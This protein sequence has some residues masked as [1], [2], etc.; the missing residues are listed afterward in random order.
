MTYAWNRLSRRTAKARQRRT[1]T[2]Y[3]RTSR[4]QHFRIEALEP[5][6]L[7]SADPLLTPVQEELTDSALTETSVIEST[8]ATQEADTSSALPSQTPISSNVIGEPPSLLPFAQTGDLFVSETVSGSILQITPSGDVSVAIS[9]TQILD[10]V[11]T[12]IGQRPDSI[13]Y[14]Q[15]GIAFDGTSESIYFVSL[16]VVFSDLS[17]ATG[18]LRIE[19]GQVD[20]L[21]TE[22]DII[23]VT[24][25]TTAQPDGLAFDSDGV[26][27][28]NED[29]SDSVI[30]IDPNSGGITI[31]A[32]EATLMAA[33][34]NPVDIDASIVGGL[35]GAMFV[36]NE[37]SPNSILKILADGTVQLLTNDARLDDLD[38][39]LTRAPDG[40]L[41]I[42]DDGN[43]DIPN[44]PDDEIF[45]VDP[46]T[47]DV[48]VFLSTAQIQAAAG[49]A[50]IDLGAGAFDSAGNFYLTDQ[51]INSILKF[52]AS[53]L[54]SVFVSEADILAVTGEAAANLNG[55]IAFAPI[56]Q[57]PATLDLTG[58]GE[59]TQEDADIILR[60][61]FGIR[62]DAL[63][64]PSSEGSSAALTDP[65]EIATFLESLET[66]ML[67]VDDNG[68]AMALTDGLLIDRFIKGLTRNDLINGVVDPTGQRTDAGEIITFLSQFVPT[69]DPPNI[70]ASLLNDTGVNLADGL[71][72]DPTITGTITDPDG[73]NIISFR[74]GF[75]GTAEEDFVDILSTFDVNTGTFIL[76]ATDLDTINGGPLSDGLHT[77]TLIA[78]DSRGESS[79]PSPIQFT[80]DTLTPSIVLTSPLQADEL[81]VDSRLTGTASGTGTPLVQ[82]TYAF[83]SGTAIPM[84]IDQMSGVVNTP[85]DLSTLGTGDHTLTV[86][87]LDAAG[88]STTTQID[89][90]LTEL[91][92]LTIRQI[93]PALGS[94][95][96]GTTFRPQIFFSRPVDPTTLNNSNFFATDSAGQLLNATI[97]PSQDNDFAWLFFTDPMPGAETIT[98]HVEG[99][100]IL[101]LAD[102]QPLDA[103]DDGTPGGTLTSIFTTVSLTP[104]PGTTIIGQVVDPG[105]DLTP[106][107]SDDIDPGP[108]GLLHT[109]DDVFLLPLPGVKVFIL[110]M[111][112]DFVLTDSEG[113]FTL[114]NV[115]AGNVKVA[116]DGRTGPN[117]PSGVFFPEMV[118]DVMIEPGLSNTLMG[119]MGTPEQQRANE[120]REE[121]YLPRIQQT[122]LQ[123]VSNTEETMVGVDEMSAPNLT[124]EQ[125]EQ[126]QLMVQPGSLIDENGN[127]IAS[128]QVGLSTVPPELVREMLPPGV[129]Q[130]TF[131]ITI[132]APEAA[133]FDT[134]LAL[135]FP[136]IFDAEPGKTLNFLSF[137]HTTGRLV[138][139][140]TATVSPD[141]QSVTTDPGQGITKPGWHG[142]TPAGSTTK[143]PTF[144]GLPQGNSDEGPNC[145]KSTRDAVDALNS[146]L[147]GLKGCAEAFLGGKIQKFLEISYELLDTVDQIR[148]LVES[149]QSAQENNS[150]A[151]LL[152]TLLDG[153]QVVLDK[154]TTILDK[155]ITEVNIA[156]KILACIDE[157]LSS[158]TSLCDKIQDA[159]C[160]TF[161]ID[162]LCFT[163]DVT[164]ST[165]SALRGALAFSKNAI[166]EATAFFLNS[167]IEALKTDLG[168]E[169]L[170]QSGALGSPNSSSAQTIPHLSETS[171][172]T[173]NYNDLSQELRDRLD[174][175][176]Q[177][178]F[179]T[180][181][182]GQDL[183][184]DIDALSADVEQFETDILNLENDAATFILGNLGLPSNTFWLV[185]TPGSELRGQTGLN[186]DLEVFLPANSEFRLD[187]YDPELNEIAS[188]EGHTSDSGQET[189]IGPVIFQPSEFTIENVV[190][191]PD[192]DGDGLVDLAEKIVGTSIETT[193]SDDDG[194]SDFAEIRNGT[195]PLGGRGL[196]SG[197]VGS[198]P[199]EGEA[200]RIIIEGSL[201]S[202][203][204]QTA[205]IATGSYGLAI[206]DASQFRTP[207]VLSQLDLS[208]DAVD[209]AVDSSLSIAA[210][211]SGTAG[212]HLI[213]VATPTNPTPLNTIPINSSQV[214][215]IDG[216]VYT[217]SGSELLAYDLLTGEQIASFSN[218][219]TITGLAHEGTTLYTMDTTQTLRS[220]SITNEN[221]AELDTLLLPSSGHNIFVGEGVAYVAAGNGSTGGFMT[222]DVTNPNA[223][224]LLSGI[225]NNG[226]AGT[227]IALNGSGTGIIAGS[228]DFAIGGFQAVDI[229]DVS[230]PTNTGAFVTR[231]DL[232]AIPFDVAIG[233]GIGFIANGTAGLQI[234]NYLQ[235]DNQRQAPLISMSIE[236]LDVDPFTPGQQVEEG[237]S[238]SLNVSVTDDVQVRN[239]ELL[240]NGNVVTNDVAFPWDLRVFAPVITPGTDSFTLQVRA[241]D[242]GGNVALSELL[243]FDLVPDST[244]P[245][246]LNQSPR[247]GELQGLLTPT[248]RLDFNEAIDEFTLTNTTIQLTSVATPNTPIVPTNLD[249]RNEGKSVHLIYGTVSPGDYQLTIQATEI[250][251]LAGN[252]LGTTDLVTDF[253]V[254]EAT[255]VW[256]NPQ[257]GF[258]DDPNNWEGGILP[259]AT[260][261]VLIRDLVEGA[262]VVHRSGQTSIRNLIVES[263]LT[264]QGPSF[265]EV[266]ETIEARDTI[267][268]FGGGIRNA[269]INGANTPLH[270]SNSGTLDSVTLNTDLTFA[271]GFTQTTILGDLIFNGQANFQGNTN[272][273]FNSQTSQLLGGTG[274]IIFAEDAFSNDRINLGSFQNKT[275][276]LGSDFTIHGGTGSLQSFEFFNQSI[277]NQGSI[278]SL[279]GTVSLAG[280]WRNE[281]T[282][283]ANNAT[284]ELSGSFATADIGTVENENGT[285]L[286]TGDLDNTGEILAADIVPGGLTLGHGAN[287]TGGTLTVL[288]NVP[289]AV[290]SLNISTSTLLTDVILDNAEFL[291]TGAIQLTG[292]W[293]NTNT[294]QTAGINLFLGGTVDSANVGII[295]P[296]NG[297][298]T[299]IGTIDNTGQT[300]DLA[301]ITGGLQTAQGGQITGGIINSTANTPIHVLANTLL[302]LDSVTLNTDLTF[303]PG[304]TQTTILG[305]LIFNGQANFQGNTNWVFNSQTSQLLGGTGTIIFAEDAFSNDR[306]NLGSF[307][308][309]TLTLG[310]DFTIHGGTGSLQSF[311]FF[312]Q[313]IL[314]Q[315]SID[316]LNGTVSLAG[317]WRN[318]GTLRANNATL[319]LS[320]SFATADIGT[321][322]NENGTILITGDLDNTGEILAADI[323]P[324]GLTL[325]HGANITGGTLTVL[326]NVPFAVNSLNIS[327]S[328]LLTDVIL[329]NAEFLGTGAIQLTGNWSNTNTLQTAGINLFLG[330]TVDSANVGIIVPTNGDTTLIGTIDNTGQTFDLADITGGLQTAQGGQIT[331]GIINSTANTPIHVLA[332]TL[333]TL[334]SVTLNTDLTFAPGFTQT[335][336]LGDLIFNGQ[337]NFQGNT[338]WVFNSQTSQ[339]L[340]GTGTII[341]A[342]DAFSNDRINLGSFQNKTL[343]LGSDFTIH[344]G[345]GSL[346]S[347]EFFNQ[348]ILNQGSILSD[349]GG[350]ISLNSP[351]AQDTL[352][353]IGIEILGSSN[354]D[355][356]RISGIGEITL[357]GTLDVITDG[358]YAPTLNDTFQILTFT[359]RNGT[360]FDTITGL[361][362]GNGLTLDPQYSDTDLTLVVVNASNLTTSSGLLDSSVSSITN[363]TLQSTPII[364]EESEDSEVDLIVAQELLPQATREEGFRDNSKDL[365]SSNPLIDDR[366]KNSLNSSNPLTFNRESQ[367]LRNTQSVES[368][369]SHLS[370]L[371]TSSE[372]MVTSLNPDPQPWLREFLEENL[373]SIPKN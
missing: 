125:R 22:A 373:L 208:G 269:T 351:F 300:F 27:F 327:T 5:R 311:E 170:A 9:E 213:D 232:P 62:G 310:S 179:H 308:N 326:N 253:T 360:Q 134:P 221:L 319:E 366:N 142:L 352:G 245:I 74:A 186:G 182:L 224:T 7:L 143:G 14:R 323:V 263:D 8:Q 190:A 92:P 2:P 16:A 155:A 204:N 154:G 107:T 261:D 209:V 229:V 79:P 60:Y 164:G 291:G 95:E 181:M 119:S 250:T 135:T 357:A 51:A 117:T 59:V 256:T 241:T 105:P 84:T 236:D 115:P 251:D 156:E 40:D 121:V 242:T 63:I 126:L 144:M 188:F 243:M 288:N 28:S 299:L 316:S 75:D 346:Q 292:N 133:A 184:E 267:Q 100:T 39:F 284:L 141:G 183:R 94:S 194:I 77:L 370:S 254:V 6:I 122:I 189:I 113:R 3:E 12:E 152:C 110:G 73:D 336:I 124:E 159:N 46:T 309:K 78:T 217:A 333:L 249:V 262:S 368:Q 198:L 1:H 355:F 103:D 298:T 64:P 274:T 90:S 111:E 266:A 172:N 223:M 173:V 359:S 313:S 20:V 294:L 86:N 246:L 101:G 140:G 339:L 307:Q 238:I 278:D 91:I 304:F 328:T 264:I 277:L 31:H 24:G 325:G 165:A 214:E 30:R 362:L 13:D 42:G 273:V 226:V 147:K 118:M 81:A 314:N 108:D 49:V 197:I 146:V 138:I 57:P 303:A 235:F 36:G 185:T 205:F 293:S 270:I 72:N 271:P 137:D 160:S 219:S 25:D 48:T 104:I 239:V 301:D 335:T 15:H 192:Q 76:N 29:D 166:F 361:D 212:L 32:D 369:N 210:V 202:G 145:D 174:A 132:Q 338:N 17:E 34:T 280:N 353:N 67:D 68:Q 331:G 272:W 112:S 260:D 21:V 337:A 371:R 330:G 127:P 275:L 240:L 200:K 312:N 169:K 66:T 65:V 358:T 80:L 332:N 234:L 45:R 82:L 290:N 61:L 187:M 175:F 199:V 317:N 252:A 258:W 54:G 4:A 102:A 178:A 247:N 296:T 222:V 97:V 345:T 265:I 259:G 196:P 191:F 211:A 329:D 350:L 177:E 44:Q 18:I 33:N 129:L 276:T 364:N 215:V 193:D 363:G 343:T 176:F 150:S 279:N 171:E 218:N 116:V 356:G 149:Y 106:M 268:L 167:G 69:N 341:F 98:L 161:F 26:L 306:I 233:A 302:T 93:T 220:F 153:M 231:F 297:D 37:E 230:D 130:H 41:I 334:D 287:I 53:G 201:S 43:S 342:E 244:S 347:F 255:A 349:A 281:G 225:D 162:T 305:D 35:D 295:V 120:T 139:E 47:G 206:V 85:L 344:G 180:F 99:D 289:F 158:A 285:I 10:A 227:A 148:M 315:G 228:S 282:L 131:D 216:I 136:N 348:S 372:D 38:A 340:G 56:P 109:D 114:T 151:E 23:A 168:E 322:E 324:G 83:D 283:R 237:T 157:L 248:V 195:D 163:I 70:T 96:I 55:G 321:V 71:T 50:T 89:V 128:G 87:A 58:D 52:D 320:G 365:E 19:D 318:E 11:E 88:N 354:N 207:V 367:I 123:A 286:I 257:G 203:E